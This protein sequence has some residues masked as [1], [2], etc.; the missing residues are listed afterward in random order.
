MSIGILTAL[1]LSVNLPAQQRKV[2]PPPSATSS[3]TGS[4]AHNQRPALD[5]TY[6][7]NTGFMIQAGGKKVL[8]DAL[9]E[10][11][12]DVLGP[13]PELLAQMTAGSG[14]FADVDFLLVTHPHSDHFNSKLV[15]E[16]L[17]H[18]VRC[19]LVAHTQVVDLLRNEE[20]FVQIEGQIHV[21]KLEPG[22]YEKI[23]LNGINLDALCLKHMA[24]DPENQPLRNMVFIVELGGVR[25]FHLGDSSIDQ[26]EAYL[27]NYPFERSPV[28]TLF[29]NR[30]DRS[31]AT[32]K[33]IAEKIK[34]SQIVAM[35]ILPAELAETTNKILA[36]YPH[37]I[38]FKESMERRSIPI[39]F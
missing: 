23:S 13:S 35:H 28:D 7:G 17:R 5:V 14:S 11:T 2:V 27:N 30:I 21:V 1:L 20:G 16:F 25:F 32:Q 3:T 4:Y 8:V 31:E 36:V 12:K 6:I 10:G 26:S 39:V 9:F 33:Y 37:A 19:Q 24:D 29:L 15:I 18:H 22:A 38:I 34:P